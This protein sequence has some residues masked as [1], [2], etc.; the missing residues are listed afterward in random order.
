MKSCENS[1]NE[2][3]K[4]NRTYKNACMHAYTYPNRIPK[5]E[6]EQK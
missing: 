2:V 4:F 3:S 1:L 6:S 5:C